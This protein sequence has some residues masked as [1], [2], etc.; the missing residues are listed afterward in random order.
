[1]SYHLE[2]DARNAVTNTTCNHT[3]S[4]SLKD[5]KHYMRIGYVTA[6]DANEVE[7]WSGLGYFIPKALEAESIEV[8]RIGPLSEH[9]DY[10]TKA[11]ALLYRCLTR[12]E[13]LLDRVP[14]VLQS[15]ADQVARKLNGLSVDIVFSPST[16]PISYLHSRTPIVFWTDATFAGMVNFYP[17][18]WS[19]LCAEA[20]KNGNIMEQTALSNARLAIYSSEWAADTAL[21]NYRVDASK[22]KVVPFGANMETQLTMDDLKGIITRRRQHSVCQLLFVGTEWHRKG[23]DIAVQLAGALNRKRK[24]TKLTVVG[25]HP[26]MELPEFVVVKDFISKGNP[27]S[28]KSFEKI[29]AESHF[30]VLPT[31][32]DCAPIAIAEANSVGLPAITTDVG[33]IPNILLNGVN[34]ASFPIAEFVERACDFIL[35]CTEDWAA[36]EQLALR[37]FDRYESALN[38]RAAARRV[39]TFLQQIGD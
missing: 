16:L 31:R 38:W 22:V 14:R 15:Y 19:N 35:S 36:Y 1:M 7:N 8:V 4:S 33:G 29:L 18:K 21:T 6:Y 27:N 12:K 24:P 10:F 5:N 11:K 23:G 30:L 20:V 2:V 37:S 28:R 3:K 9:V 26:Q 25:C 13:L 39:K 34:G 32:A 17:G